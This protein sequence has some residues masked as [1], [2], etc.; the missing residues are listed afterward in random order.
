MTNRRDVLKSSAFLAGGFAVSGIPQKSICNP[1]APPPT[2]PKFNENI[3]NAYCTTHKT[4][5]IGFNQNSVTAAELT[6]LAT[7]FATFVNEMNS[8]GYA[9]TVQSSI[10]SNAAVISALD[11]A[12]VDVSALLAQA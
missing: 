4:A 10:T 6:A 7:A 12:T 11:A 5:S 1:T 9:S 2:L 8:T 3:L